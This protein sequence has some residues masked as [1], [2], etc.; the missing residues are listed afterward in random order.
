MKRTSLSVYLLAAVAVPG[1]GLPQVVTESAAD[2]ERHIIAAIEQEQSRNGPHA[3]QLIA[4]LTALALFYQEGGDHALAAAATERVLQLVRVNY[5]LHSLEQAPVI[6]RLMANE[7]AIGNAETAW[8]LDQEL[9]ALARRH[10]SDLRTV[11]ILH[12]L[13][14]SRMKRWSTGELTAQVVCSTAPAQAPTRAPTELADLVAA[15]ASTGPDCSGPRY[16]GAYG[17]VRHETLRNYAE[18]I[19]VLRRNQLYSSPELR[20]LEME[21]VRSGNCDLAKESYRRLMSYNTANSEP[22]L[23]RTTTFV[24]AADLELRCSDSG[25]A[26]GMY[27]QSYALLKQNGVAQTSMDEMFSPEVP[28]VLSTALPNPLPTHQTIEG[29]GYIDVR[30]DITQDGKARSI[31]VLDATAGAADAFKDRLVELIEAS[32]FR[33][34][35]MNGHIARRAPVS[36]RYYVNE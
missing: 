34:K 24:E 22:L 5:G 2:R 1:V 15:P 31:D 13:A 23:E 26:L 6:E 30:F 19:D 20:E 32:L 28:V 10:P 8:E 33:P 12:E 9:L 14:D 25:V 16:A 7:A 36:I 21:L 17:I 3:E 29:Q 4:P 35:V 18:A 27:E 11:S